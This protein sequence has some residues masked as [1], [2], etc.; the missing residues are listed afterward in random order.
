LVWPWWQLSTGACAC[1]LV[2]PWFVCYL[3]GTLCC[4][5]Q[6]MPKAGLL[7]LPVTFGVLLLVF[8]ATAGCCCKCAS[9]KLKPPRGVDREAGECCRWVAASVQALGPGRWL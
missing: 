6:G 2:V 4:A 1:V 7:G 9:G 3:L 5:R 8:Q